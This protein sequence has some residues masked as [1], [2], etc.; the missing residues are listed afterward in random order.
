VGNN[1]KFFSSSFET[2]DRGAIIS[3]GAINMLLRVARKTL[4]LISLH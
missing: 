3:V 1:P 2:T 4:S